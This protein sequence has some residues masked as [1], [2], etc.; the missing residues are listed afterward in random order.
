MLELDQAPRGRSFYD[1]MFN[2]L[3]LDLAAQFGANSTEADAETL[4]APTPPMGWNSWDAY[5][6]T[7]SE[8]DIKANAAWMA[9]HLKSYGWEYILLRTPAGT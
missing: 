2:S 8:S 3:Y 6:E 1:G 5:G 9:E 7:V 4:L